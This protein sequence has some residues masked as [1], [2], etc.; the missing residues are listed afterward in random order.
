VSNLGLGKGA[1][2]IFIFIC[3]Q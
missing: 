3:W 2:W 1:K